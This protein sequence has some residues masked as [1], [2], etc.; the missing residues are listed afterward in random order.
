[1]SSL[2]IPSY[3]Q[4]F[5]RCAAESANPGLWHG[6]AGLWAPTLGPTG[7]TLR[8][9]SGHQNHGTLTDMAPATDWVPSRYGYVLDFNAAGNNKIVLSKTV[10]TALS[11]MTVAFWACPI[12]TEYHGMVVGKVAGH[13]FY[14][15]SF[16]WAS[17]RALWHDGVAV[18]TLSSAIGYAAGT[19]AHV[20]YTN[21]ST[22]QSLFTNGVQRANAAF[23]GFDASTLSVDLCEGYSNPNY[24]FGGLV[25]LIAIWSRALAPAEI[26]Q[27]Y[28]DPHALLRLRRRVF[29]AAAVAGIAPTSH[30]YGSLVGPLGGAV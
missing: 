2:L 27:L 24:N 11:A 14:M 26:Q 30:L 10:I 25:A 3:G 7:S 8:D 21:N 28:V 1:M 20:A 12:N 29:A 15:E 4:G 23:S 6:L 16:N 17:W 9:W 13:R 22:A 5:A 18:R 19:W